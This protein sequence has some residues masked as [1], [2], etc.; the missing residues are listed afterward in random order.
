MSDADALAP[1]VEQVL[2]SNPAEVERYRNGEQKLFGFFVGQA[3][4]AT[5][6]T[7]DPKLLQQVLREKLT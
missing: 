3:M 6:G 4:R 5:G 7:A 2:A 1:V